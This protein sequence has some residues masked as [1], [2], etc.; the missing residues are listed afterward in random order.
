LTRSSAMEA[1]TIATSATARQIFANRIAH[2]AFDSYA[3]KG[4]LS[5]AERRQESSA[6]AR[7]RAA[8][9]NCS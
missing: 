9:K 1:F 3:K 8:W 5:P 4:T 7:F 2:L 6:T